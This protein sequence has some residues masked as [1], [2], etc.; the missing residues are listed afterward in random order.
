MKRMMLP[1]KRMI[2]KHR[3]GLT[4]ERISIETLYGREGD[5]FVR[6]EIFCIAKAIPE[7]WDRLCFSQFSL[8]YYKCDDCYNR[9]RLDEFCL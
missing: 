1:K 3:R 4:D 8:Q 7:Y 5:C 9:P 6:I 2:R